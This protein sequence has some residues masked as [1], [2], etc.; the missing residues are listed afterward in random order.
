[1]DL[2][3]ALAV[4]PQT[5][6]LN[7]V[8]LV[9]GEYYSIYPVISN[10]QPLILPPE[11]QILSRPRVSGI[12]FDLRRVTTPIGTFGFELTNSIA[13]K[14][15]TKPGN[16]LETD[17]SLWIGDALNSDWQEY[18]KL[19]SGIIIDITA[20]TN[21]F[22]FNCKEILDYIFKDFK[23]ESILAVP[24]GTTETNIP[25][26]DTTLFQSAGSVFVD[27]E[28]IGYTGKT[29]YELQGA[30]R[31][32]FGSPP[33][34]HNGLVPIYS[35]YH[36]FQ[37]NPITIM[38]Q[39]L[40]SKTGNGSNSAY[41]VLQYG[42]GL[43]Q[44]LVDIPSFEAIRLEW[45]SDA[46]FTLEVYNVGNLLSFF[47][48]EFLQPLNCRLVTNNGK[49]T[50][51]LLDNYTAD[52]VDPKFT[53]DIVIGVPSWKIESNK[54]INMVEVSYAYNFPFGV[55]DAKKSYSDADSIALFGVKA[56]QKFEF[57]GITNDASGNALI[58]RLI[59][60]FLLR[61][62]RSRGSIQLQ[63][64]YN[65][66][67]VQ[68]G[69]NVL[70]DHR[71]VPQVGQGM[72]IS[73]ILENISKSI[74]L[75]TGNVQ[76]NLEFMST[77]EFRT[78]IIAPSGKITSFSSQSVFT[79]D[80]I[81]LY[82][83][84]FRVELMK[85]LTTGISNS[86]NQTLTSNYLPFNYFAGSR[87]AITPLLNGYWPGTNIQ[88]DG[89]DSPAPLKIWSSVTQFAAGNDL[90]HIGNVDTALVW[91]TLPF[92]SGSWNVPITVEIFFGRPIKLTA[93]ANSYLFYC[94]NLTTTYIAP[95][96]WTL[97]G[98]NDGL[99]YDLLDT[100]TNQN[101]PDDAYTYCALAADTKYYSRFR[102]TI[103]AFVT[104]PIA[105]STMLITRFALLGYDGS[106]STVFQAFD[107]ETLNV[108]RSAAAFV[109]GDFISYK[110]INPFFIT[111]YRIHRGTIPL[112]QLPKSFTL[113]ASNDGI[114]FTTLDTQTNITWIAA[115]TSKVFSFAKTAT[116]YLI[117]KLTITEIQ[118][119]ASD[120]ASIAY[121]EILDAYAPPGG[122]YYLPDAYKTI[123]AINGNTITVNAPFT[124]TLEN[125]M[126]IKLARFADATAIMK[127]KFG[128]IGYNGANF[129]DGSPPYLIIY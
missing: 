86:I 77:A 79:V 13:N 70:L 55:F 18:T 81:N 37:V 96:S 127:K 66:F 82:E 56:V 61:M 111:A 24:I 59:E 94:R 95:K 12:S 109:S 74:D 103:T 50:L 80:K 38:L 113:S 91:K 31:G 11:N 67:D 9:A 104:P 25:V 10:F 27:G 1:M 63:T 108:W 99:V 123:T 7:V 92:S 2:K 121:L 114:N 118:G 76:F 34:S 32:I 84:G 105:A 98:S 62:S 51:T 87:D 21:G 124:T 52:P 23:R 26:I 36:F 30:T 102:W 53:E 107:K 39:L 89:I 106:L 16:W 69:S 65:A 100:K 93:G 4:E 120:F 119:T 22:V 45:F 90:W 57:K 68:L 48:T 5:T 126:S 112:A 43:D 54:I 15:L 42:L 122:N 29:A 88:F 128:Y 19:M 115:D 125:G 85:Y 14:M 40:L 129:P 71:Y 116:S 58:D 64:Y 8:A 33:K 72:G 49:I 47:E 44:A 46:K 17:C 101:P 3:N 110:A 78:A 117:V 97:H 20:K 60:K 28:F 35:N 73:T 83:V 6:Q 75:G 41:D